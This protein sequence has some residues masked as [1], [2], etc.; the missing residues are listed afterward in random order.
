M[1]NITIAPGSLPTDGSD[2][3]NV[4][5]TNDTILEGDEDFLILINDTCLPVGMPD[6]TTVTIID[7]GRLV[8]NFSLQTRTIQ[9]REHTFT[10]SFAEGLAL[11]RARN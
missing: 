10:S 7:N 4:T 6:T 9:H 2:C 8:Q 11:N 1:S 5:A 3:I